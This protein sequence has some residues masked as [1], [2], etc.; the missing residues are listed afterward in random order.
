M[1]VIAVIR[2]ERTILPHFMAHHRNLGVRCF[3][4]IDNR[5]NDGSTEYILEQSDTIV[6]SAESDYKSSH[7]GVSWQRTVLAHHCIGKWVIMVDADEFFIY[8]D[9]EKINIA[10]WISRLEENSQTA[11]LT[12]QI[13]MY[14]NRPLS[15]VDFGRELPLTSARWF[16]A[17]PLQAWH[18]GSGCYS[19]SPTYLS[20]FRHR[21]ID[22]APPNAFTAQK[23]AL[24]K[25]YP[26]IHFSEGLHYASNVLTGSHIAFLAHFKYHKEFHQKVLIETQ[27]EQHFGDA[28]EYREYSKWLSFFEEAGVLADDSDELTSSR[29]LDHVEKSLNFS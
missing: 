22:N 8:P 3:I 10:D 4:F 7:Y 25:Y 13:D 27:R 16:D 29:K 9:F 15:E 2:N 5:S 28:S 12:P 18:L 11:A 26:W 24:I 21:V 20:S 19:N 17:K 14:P 23:F 6:Y 1:V